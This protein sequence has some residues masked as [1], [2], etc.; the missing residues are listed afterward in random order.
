MID[1]NNNLKV[2]KKMGMKAV[3]GELN[4]INAIDI[5]KTGELSFGL[6]NLQDIQAHV[7]MGHVQLMNL[8]NLNL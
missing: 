1:D 4:N 5:T 3:K 7:N 6:V 8:N 2:N